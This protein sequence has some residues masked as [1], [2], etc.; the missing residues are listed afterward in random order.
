[1]DA[2]CVQSL[3]Q[4]FTMALV[5]LRQLQSTQ[6]TDEKLRE[7]VSHKQLKKIESYYF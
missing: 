5:A 2:C 3:L 6:S 4:V 7:Q 1:M